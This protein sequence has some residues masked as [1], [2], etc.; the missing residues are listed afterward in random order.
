[1][2]GEHASA[3]WVWRFHDTKACRTSCK[4]CECR[5]GNE[6]QNG[7][8]KNVEPNKYAAIEMNGRPVL[9]G[10]FVF[11]SN[12]SLLERARPLAAETAVDCKRLGSMKRLPAD[13]DTL[14]AGGALGVVL[15]LG[16]GGALGS[17]G[18]AAA[19]TTTVELDAGAG[20]SDTVALACAAGRSAGDG[21]RGAGTGAAGSEGR[22]VGVGVRVRIVLGVIL[23]FVRVVDVGGGESSGELLD[24]WAGEGLG[25]EGSAGMGLLGHRGLDLRRA[26]GAALWDV[27]DAARSAG[28]LVGGSGSGGL[29]RGDVEDVELAASGGLDDGVAGGIVRDVVA[30]DDVVVPVALA[31]LQGLALEAE[32]TLPATSFGGILGERE[33]AVVVVPGSEKVHRLA[34]GRSAESEVEL[35][36]GHYD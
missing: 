21:R 4:P 16:L 19:R 2:R 24:G 10:E 36:G 31:L 22:D 33:L 35:D 25:A 23:R 13:D 20:T 28:G 17:V 15:I 5:T 7:R 14:A 18:V 12:G 32:S 3:A 11:S 30:I 26:E 8:T 9:S 1:L 6:L 34:V 29:A 27:R